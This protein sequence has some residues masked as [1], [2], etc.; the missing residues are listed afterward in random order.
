VLVLE[1]F[2][3]RVNPVTREAQVAVGEDPGAVPG[4]GESRLAAE[5]ACLRP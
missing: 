2:P 4:A 3:V 5:A 1:L